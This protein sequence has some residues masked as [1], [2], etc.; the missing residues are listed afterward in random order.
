MDS[1]EKEWSYGSRVEH[2]LFDKSGTLF[3]LI[4]PLDARMAI[5]RISGVQVTSNTGTVQVTHLG[6]RAM[7][8]ISPLSIPPLP[9]IVM[10]FE[11]I[12]GMEPIRFEG[13]IESRKMRRQDYEYTLRLE[14]QPAQEGRLL[15]LCSELVRETM[16]TFEY[17]ADT[18]RKYV[19]GQEPAAAGRYV[20]RL[21]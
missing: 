12:D 19:P 8:F 6:T 17:A 2:Q 9:P 11:L 16:R 14:L 20:E 10:G 5:L 1:E 18:Y 7:R 21:Q 15:R 13:T 4:R 3:R